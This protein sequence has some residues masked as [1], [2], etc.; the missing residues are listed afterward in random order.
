MKL[1]R[2]LLGILPIV[3]LLVMTVMTCFTFNSL[4]FL[5]PISL[6]WKMLLCFSPCELPH[7][8]PTYTVDQFYALLKA[9]SEIQKEC[10]TTFIYIIKTKRSCNYI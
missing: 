7:H 5:K 3:K 8:V 1:K 4:R 10:T 2:I 9:D 6:Y